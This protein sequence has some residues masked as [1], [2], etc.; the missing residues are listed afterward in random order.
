MELKLALR[1]MAWESMQMIMP[2]YSENI[3]EPKMPDL[4]QDLG[5]D[6]HMLNP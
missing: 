6:Y 2:I 4:R 5:W 1:I 3:I